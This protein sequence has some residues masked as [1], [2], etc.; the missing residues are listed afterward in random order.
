MRRAVR[1]AGIL[2]TVIGLAASLAGL[3]GAAEKVR[4]GLD[5]TISG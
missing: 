5:F 1:M 3:A 2:V 4:A